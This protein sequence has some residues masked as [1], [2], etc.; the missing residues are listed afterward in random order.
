VLPPGSCTPAHQQNLGNQK[1]GLDLL[2]TA[3]NI[4]LLILNPKHRRYWEEN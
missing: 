1:K 3:K 4:I 2:A